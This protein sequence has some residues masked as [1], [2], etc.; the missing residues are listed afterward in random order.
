MFVGCSSG[1]L[2]ECHKLCFVDFG[3]RVH[4]FPITCDYGGVGL[5]SVDT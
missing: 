4:D 3:H 1:G 5:E 2:V